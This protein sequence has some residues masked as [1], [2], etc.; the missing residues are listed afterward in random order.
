[1]THEAVGSKSWGDLLA[2][3]RLPRFALICLGVW[4]NAADSLVT[5]TI[6]PDVGADLG[7]FAYFSWATAGF[8]V[9]AILAGA[10][11]G[12]LSEMFG[13]RTATALAGL[14]MTVGCVMSAAAPDIGTFLAG[15]IVQ[16]LGSGWISGFAM[17]AIALLFPER[18]LARVFASVS[19]VW[20]IA[21]LLG[22]AVGGLLLEVGDWRAV[23]WIFAAQALAFS[24]ATPFLLKDS[25]KGDGGPGIPWLQLGVLGLGVAAIAVANITPGAALATLL[26]VVGVAV[27][28]LVLWIDHRAKVR[29]LPHRAG[30][31]G[32][33]VGSGYAAMFWLTA[34][35]MGF[36]I[37]APPILQEL[38][39][40]T[41]LW[42]GY[43]IGVESLAWTV[44]ALA[45]AHV[46]G[47]WDARWTRIGAV[48]LVA[49]L[50]ILAWTLADGHLAWVLVGGAL[51]G[52]AFGF[53]WSFM[54]RRIM[55]A[56]SDEDRAIGSSAITAVRQTGAAA[57]AAISGVAAN[58][59]GFS[60]GLTAETA[61]AASLWVFASVIPLALVGTWAAFRLTGSAERA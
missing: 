4:L 55:A 34:A 45:V 61:R 51:M 26:V 36:A 43:V 38:R 1:M 49:S 6:M 16:G 29:L 50:F 13:L 53:S 41:P 46:A 59:A 23:F 15:R 42:A 20:G 44:T 35:S 54:G 52:A 14:I 10:S 5:A 28:G 30:D 18:H 8:F 37:Y 9:G 2:E 33:I 25:N 11:A 56:L 24:A 60:V 7:G 12:R 21:T 19:G 32:T 3:G 17:V 58:L 47:A 27:L 39:G 22:P 48:M 31:V 40:F 57:G